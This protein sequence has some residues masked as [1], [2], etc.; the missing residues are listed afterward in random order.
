VQAGHLVVL[1]EQ[2]LKVLCHHP[3]LSKVFN[4]NE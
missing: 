4:D 2:R 3:P 1:P